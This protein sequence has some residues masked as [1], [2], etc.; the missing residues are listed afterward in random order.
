[1]KYLCLLLAL[2]T[3]HAHA[4]VSTEIRPFISGSLK[5]IQATHSGQAFILSLWSASCTHCPA[6]LKTLGQLKKKYPALR[7]VL[8]ATD[9][10]N[11]IVQLDK[12]TKQFGLA[13]QE[14]WVFADL[15]SEK[16]R[17][18]IDPRWYGELPRTYFFNKEHQREGISGVV[19]PEQLEHWITQQVK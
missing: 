5:E 10:P 3:G 18:E 9:T 15:Q 13:K 16:L 6:E 4:E 8:I 14:Q 12:L 19:P 7:I 2:L 1:M 17:F 11:E